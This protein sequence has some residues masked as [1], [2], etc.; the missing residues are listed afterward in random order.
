MYGKDNAVTPVIVL[1]K[2]PELEELLSITL[3]TTKNL[4]NSSSTFQ[5]HVIRCRELIFTEPDI[6]ATPAFNSDNTFHVVLKKVL[7][8]TGKLQTRFSK[9]GLTSGDPQPVTAALFQSCLHYT[10]LARIA[11]CWNKAGQWLIQGRDF[12]SHEG[13]LNA[14]KMDLVVSYGQIHLSL[15][16][17]TVR[18]PALQLCDIEILPKSHQ[19]FLESSD[20]VISG[21][22]IGSPWCHVLPS[23]KKGE[24]VGIRRQ[25]P[26]DAPFRSYREIKRYWKNSY[27]YRLPENEDDRIYYQVHF[28]PLGPRI[29]TYPDVCLRSRDIHCLPRVEPRPILVAFLQ[30]MRTKMSTICGHRLQ[31]QSRANYL[32]TDLLS[33]NQKENEKHN[34][35]SSNLSLRNKAPKKVIYRNFPIPDQNPPPINSLSLATKPAK[36]STAPAEGPRESHN[37]PHN[38][39]NSQGCRATSPRPLTESPETR[40][41]ATG[42]RHESAGSTPR[43]ARSESQSKGPSP[44]RLQSE[45]QPSDA[46]K[47]TVCRENKI[48]PKFFAKKSSNHSTKIDSVS[49]ARSS[50]IVPVFK[51]KCNRA[52]SNNLP[53]PSSDSSEVRNLTQPSPNILSTP[54]TYVTTQHP[55]RSAPPSSVR[56]GPVLSQPSSLPCTSPSIP[57]QTHP[58]TPKPR[59]AEHHAHFQ[60]TSFDRINP[61]SGESLICNGR[62]QE[63]GHPVFSG[64]QTPR[65]QLV[66]SGN[67]FMTPCEVS[68]KRRTS[69]EQ[70][71][72]DDRPSAAK[73]PRAKPSVQD[74]NVEA[75]AR[76]GQL[77]KVNSITLMTWLKGRGL[78]CKSKDKKPEL[79]AKVLCALNVR[80][81]EQ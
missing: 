73:R 31:L 26:A 28:R 49:S 35:D 32:T 40:D 58:L 54:S 29:F 19:Q 70:Q 33:I 25:L 72:E 36:S 3:W 61:S 45:N 30:D 21:E 68:V 66:R 75:L 48:I 37:L 7:Y 24:I 69:N 10:L 18:F 64:S 63:Y 16:A 17:S 15:V 5:P 42:S 44:P 12:L 41:R 74:V 47:V 65:P 79:V 13:Y 76:E 62:Q 20:F 11:P 9:T 52:R 80:V 50:T 8:N 6:I 71:T 59:G 56:S 57:R 38:E 4:N 2:C 34:Q 23:M 39:A 55:L 53:E 27:G 14:I 46:I 77:C 43:P 51:V 67:E 81:N 22:A 78:Q 60:P 1:A